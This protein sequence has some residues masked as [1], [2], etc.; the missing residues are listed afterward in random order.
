[1]NSVGWLILSAG[2]AA[3]FNPC[4]IAMLPSFITYLLGD[5]TS[6]ARDGL[7]AG[8]LMTAGFISVFLLAGIVSMLFAHLL[9]SLISWIAFAV[10]I[11]FT[12][13]GIR[14]VI[15]KKGISL[16]TSVQL[17]VKKGKTRSLY[18]YGIAYALASLGCTLPIFS[19]L[20]LSSF[21]STGAAIGL[22]KFILYAVGMGA[23]VTT[24]SLASTLSRKLVASFVQKGAH[25]M[26]LLSSW[27]MLLT[28]IYL[29]YYWF[30][31][32]GV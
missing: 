6:R 7:V 19:V 25:V 5:K 8:L 29:L 21:A 28:G 14:M 11:V 30:P 32:L 15:W 3:A 1:M 10:G 2:G 17:D 9:G 23:V 13:I 4:G 22:I 31:H 24:I 26:E 18:L 16:D 20:V 12:I 27:M